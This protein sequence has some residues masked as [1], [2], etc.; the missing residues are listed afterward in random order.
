MKTSSKTLPEHS[1]VC[2]SIHWPYGKEM[3]Y[4]E[5]STHCWVLPHHM[6]SIAWLV[7]LAQLVRRAHGVLQGRA[8]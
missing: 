1:W 4:A 6:H 2:H 3:M 8:F 7:Q 5:E